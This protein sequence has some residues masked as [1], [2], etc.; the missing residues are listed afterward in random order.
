MCTALGLN[1]GLCYDRLE[2]N[3]MGYS[4][5]F[6]DAIKHTTPLQCSNLI[7]CKSCGWNKEFLKVTDL[8]LICTDNCCQ[9][10]GG[11]FELISSV[12]SDGWEVC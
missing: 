10:V 5:D 4:W 2:I 3:S 12:V 1:P 8:F 6:K 7:S 9:R 11:Q